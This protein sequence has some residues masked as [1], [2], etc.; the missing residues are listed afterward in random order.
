MKLLPLLCIILSCNLHASLCE[1]RSKSAT[2]CSFYLNEIKDNSALRIGANIESLL[3]QSC[4]KRQNERLEFFTRKC[5]KKV[6][7]FSPHTSCKDSWRSVDLRTF[8]RRKGCDSKFLTDRPGQIKCGNKYVSVT[9]LCSKE[10][11]NQTFPGL[12]LTGEEVVWS[13]FMPEQTIVLVPILNVRAESLGKKS[14]LD[15]ISQQLKNAELLLHSVADYYTESAQ[16]TLNTSMGIILPYYSRNYHSLNSLAE[17]T[18]SKER[19]TYFQHLFDSFQQISD[20][21]NS[22]F[23]KM[24]LVNF[25]YVPNGTTASEFGAA[26]AGNFGVLP[27]RAS[28]VS[29]QNFWQSPKDFHQMFYAAAHELGHSFGLT[30]TPPYHPVVSKSIMHNPSSLKIKTNA[31]LTSKQINELEDFFQDL[32]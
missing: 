28:R 31:I 17:S 1:K 10:N 13:C 23:K 14:L 11:G 7:A 5:R 19:F 22:A 3:N 6:K 16:V 4:D 25:S 30:H 21:R 27:P 24:R 20:S 18:H 29:C 2:N 26:N 32:K 8:K 15:D 9:K 12:S